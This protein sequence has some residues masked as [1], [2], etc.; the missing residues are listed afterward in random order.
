[1]IAD[2]RQEAILVRWIEQQLDQLTAASEREKNSLDPSQSVSR[3][4]I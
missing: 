2:C 3:R 4:Y 1:M